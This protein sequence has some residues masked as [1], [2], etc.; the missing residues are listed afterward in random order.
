MSIIL[1]QQQFAGQ[2]DLPGRLVQYTPRLGSSGPGGVITV[3][4]TD[5]TAK[6][7]DFSLAPSGASR[8][9]PSGSAGLQCL[10]SRSFGYTI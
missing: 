6:Q 10:D 1:Q 4:T 3:A 2:R 8:S 5:K 7:I 9:L